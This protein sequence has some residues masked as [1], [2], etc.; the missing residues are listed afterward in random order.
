MRIAGVAD[1]EAERDEVGPQPPDGGVDDGIE[2]HGGPPVPLTGRHCQLTARGAICH[3]GKP[4]EADNDRGH[5]HLL[6]RRTLARLDRALDAGGGGSALPDRAARSSQGRAEGARLPRPQSDGQGAGDR[7][8]GCG[9][10]RGGGDL[11]LSRRRLPGG[12]PGARRSATRSGAPTCAGCSSSPPPR[13]RDRRPD[14]GAP[15]RQADGSGLRRLRHDDGRGGASGDARALPARRAFLDGRR[16]DR[17]G[18][19]MGNDGGQRAAAAGIRGV[20]RAAER[21]PG[22]AAGA[23]ARTRNSPPAERQTS[24]PRSGCGRR[25]APPPA[26]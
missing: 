11:L 19:A 16:A 23:G 7:S 15:A 22:P 13:A 5:D 1:S 26:R 12:G 10:H 8:S 18:A 4:R 17:L 21:P 25:G 20:C 14:A 6:P 9:D 24:A 3:A 2:G